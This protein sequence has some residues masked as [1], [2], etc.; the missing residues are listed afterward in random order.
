MKFRFGVG[1]WRCALRARRV[2]ELD[3]DWDFELTADLNGYRGPGGDLV[4]WQRDLSLLPVNGTV[5]GA[6][7]RAEICAVAGGGCRWWA[8]GKDLGERVYALS[9]RDAVLQCVRFWDDA[10]VRAGREDDA[11]RLLS[12]EARSMR[13]GHFDL[14]G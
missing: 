7:P 11:Y 8:D 9:L 1:R 5:C 3:D 10:L 4:R 6:A 13:D 12:A 14:T 2:D